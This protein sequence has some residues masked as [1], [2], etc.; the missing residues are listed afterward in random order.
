MHSLLSTSCLENMVFSSPLAFIPIAVN[1]SVCTFTPGALSLSLHS[2]KAEE[3]EENDN[4]IPSPKAK[5]YCRLL[6]LVLAC[7]AIIPHLLS[8]DLRFA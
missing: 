2:A 5:R 7:L 6:D 1:V 4:A 3:T 8:G